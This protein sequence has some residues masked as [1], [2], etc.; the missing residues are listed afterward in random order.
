MAD[1]SIS[2]G[3]T[4][5]AGTRYQSDDTDVRPQKSESSD[6]PLDLPVLNLWRAIGDGRLGIAY[7]TARLTPEEDRTSAVFPPVDLIAATALGNSVYGPEGEIVKELENHFSAI[8]DLTRYDTQVQEKAQDAL[9]LLLFSAALRPAIFAPQTGALRILKEVKLL[10][11][12]EPVSELARGVVNKVH[13]FYNVPL[14]FMRLQAALNTTFLENRFKD[15]VARVET[16]REE[17]K[18]QRIMFAPAHEVWRRWQRK[19]EILHDLAE[20]LSNTE[21]KKPNEN[22]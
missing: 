13:R 19:G 5:N 9:N 2:N 14:D 10:D 3:D 21:E 1:N 17:A 16:W 8:G 6:A 15:Y 22:S 18:T 7:H 11:K 12:L 4:D 20:L